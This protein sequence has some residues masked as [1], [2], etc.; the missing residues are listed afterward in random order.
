MHQ[1][2]YLVLLQSLGTSHYLATA[3]ARQKMNTV[4]QSP[5]EIRFFTAPRYERIMLE[6]IEKLRRFLQFFSTKQK[7]DNTFIPIQII[8]Q[9]Q[10][11]T[12]FHHQ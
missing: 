2:M 7:S 10:I 8:S 11:I 6:V 1:T 12:A 9:I 4:Q 5:R 3:K